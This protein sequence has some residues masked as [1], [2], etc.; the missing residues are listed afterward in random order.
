ME[1]PSL[2][3]RENCGHVVSGISEENLF[4]SGC[5]MVVDV[6]SKDV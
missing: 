5:K 4:R 3:L 6:L 1:E 2:R